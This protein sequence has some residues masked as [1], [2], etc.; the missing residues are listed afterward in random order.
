MYCANVALCDNASISA[1]IDWTHVMVCGGGGVKRGV[2]LY[3][4]AHCLLSL[5]LQYFDD[6]GW[7]AGRASG[8]LNKKA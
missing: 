7:V 2:L 4:L 3:I 8:Q 6:V 1:D 5:S